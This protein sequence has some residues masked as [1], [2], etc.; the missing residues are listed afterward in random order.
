MGGEAVRFSRI[1]MNYSD[2]GGFIFHRASKA[3]PLWLVKRGK[4][5][6]KHQLMKYSLTCLTI[7]PYIFGHF[8]CWSFFSVFC[9]C[10]RKAKIVRLKVDFFCLLWRRLQTSFQSSAAW[11]RKTLTHYY[12]TYNYEI[13]ERA[14]QSTEPHRTHACSHLFGNEMATRRKHQIKYARPLYLPL[15]LALTLH[16]LEWLF[17]HVLPPE[18]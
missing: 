14:H 12:L 9:N 6:R 7:R 5:R 3:V 17:S 11:W 8:F 13:S 18:R 16:Y 1:I 2:C 10:S 4:G 15:W